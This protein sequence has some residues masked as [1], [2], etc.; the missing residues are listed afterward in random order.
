MT[1]TCQIP[2][3]RREYGMLYLGKRICWPCWERLAR[4]DH[5]AVRRGLGIKGR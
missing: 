4:R 3:C 5:D 1:T 2:R